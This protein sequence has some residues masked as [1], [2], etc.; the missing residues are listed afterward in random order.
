MQVGDV[1]QAQRRRTF[2]PVGGSHRQAGQAEPE[3]FYRRPPDKRQQS[4][5]LQANEQTG[6][7]GHT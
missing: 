5:R 3:R 2:R 4:G 1:Q 7:P 6:S